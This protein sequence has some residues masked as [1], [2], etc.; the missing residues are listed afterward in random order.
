[1]SAQLSSRLA[2]LGL[3]VGLAA[4][5][6]SPATGG[7]DAGTDARVVGGWLGCDQDVPAGQPQCPASAPYCCFSAALE[8]GSVCNGTF[9]GRCREQPVGG[10]LTDCD[11]GSGAGCPAGRPLCCEDRTTPG[12][13]YCSD[14]AYLGGGWVCSRPQQIRAIGVDN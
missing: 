3:L 11:P 12:T 4:A 9:F 14:H 10:L 7:S 6:G 8:A 5:C 1:M 13:R 2:L